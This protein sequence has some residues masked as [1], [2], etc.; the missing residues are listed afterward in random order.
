[1]PF[2]GFPVELRTVVYS[3]NAIESLDARFRRVVATGA[4]SP[5]SRQRSKCRIWW[6]PKGGRTER[7]PPGRSTP[8]PHPG[9]T[10]HPLGRP[11]PGRHL[12]MEQSRPLTQE[13][14][15]SLGGRGTS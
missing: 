14:G 2:L 12:A 4:T 9:R 10:H 1:V 7:T 6:R 3:T 13:I 11:H 5:T 15:Q 8:E